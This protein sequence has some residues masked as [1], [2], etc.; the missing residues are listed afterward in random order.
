MSVFPQSKQR[1][2]ITHLAFVSSAVHA[3]FQQS[4]WLPLLREQPLLTDGL[5][6]HSRSLISETA[7]TKKQAE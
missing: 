4:P 3:H 2:F 6:T 5:G 7:R 1:I